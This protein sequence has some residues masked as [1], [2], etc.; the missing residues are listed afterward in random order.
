MFCALTEVYRGSYRGK[1]VAVKVLKDSGAL[2]SMLTEASVMTY[3][4]TCKLSLRLLLVCHMMNLLSYHLFMTIVVAIG[5]IKN[6]LQT[7]LIGIVC[8]LYVGV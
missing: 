1:D 3:V 4:F 8:L 2:S 6:K 7:Y 5:S